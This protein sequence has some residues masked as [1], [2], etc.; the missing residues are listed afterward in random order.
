MKQLNESLTT[1]SV[2]LSGLLHLISR[3][4]AL[5]ITG[6]HFRHPQAAVS[7]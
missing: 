3:E 6:L 1:R 5:R 7:A 2:A 4:V